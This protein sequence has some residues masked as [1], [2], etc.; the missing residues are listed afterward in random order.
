[1]TAELAT[2]DGEIVEDTQPITLFGTTD[3]VAVVERASSVATALADVLKQKRLAVHIGNRDHV[4]VEGWTLLGSMLGVFAEV[5][6]TR[7]TENGWEARAVARTL[8]GRTVGAAEAMCSK[9]EG[10]WRNRDDYAIRSMAQT[11]AVSKAL[12]LPLGFIME[13]AGYS[14]TPAEELNDE[15]GQ[16]ASPS[17]QAAAQQAK[18]VPAPADLR[19]ELAQVAAAQRMDLKGIEDYAEL[20]GFPKG[21]RLND[22]QL[23]QLIE[24]VRG[25]GTDAELV[26]PL[27][28]E[29]SAAAP[30]ASEE[31]DGGAPPVADPVPPKPGSDEY[32]ALP[33]GGARADARDYWQKQKVTA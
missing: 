30:P 19:V 7:P 1:M 33:D 11:R 27:E 20:L 21:Q 9:S 22:E 3:P 31:S 8:N 15:S 25:H 28:Q 23:R 17:R 12:R 2:I 24:A 26:L 6:W 10:T 4:L 14:A 32:K 16:G 29:A 18:P 5:E 13:L